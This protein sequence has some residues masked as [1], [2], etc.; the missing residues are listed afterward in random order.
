M[1][2]HVNNCCKVAVACLYKDEGITGIIM[3]CHQPG[4]PITEWA[5]MREGLIIAGMLR[6]CHN[7]LS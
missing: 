3:F 6:Y 4:G 1:W 5:Y 7:R 2:L